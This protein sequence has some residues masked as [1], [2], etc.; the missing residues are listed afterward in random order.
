M[1][2]GV[3]LKEFLPFFGNYLIDWKLF[4]WPIV[5]LVGF[6]FVVDKDEF[7]VV[8][9]NFVVVGMVVV[10]DNLMVIAVAGSEIVYLAVF[11][12]DN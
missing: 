7:V 12:V 9:G 3:A 4:V 5:D 1:E 10:V 8:V 11:V 6:E 2:F